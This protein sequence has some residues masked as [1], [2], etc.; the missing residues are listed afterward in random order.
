MNSSD[1]IYRREDGKW[2]KIDG[3]LKCVSVGP[4]GVWGCNKS[5]QVYYRTGTYGDVGGAGKSVS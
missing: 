5:D 4:S 3:A 2:Q 1:G